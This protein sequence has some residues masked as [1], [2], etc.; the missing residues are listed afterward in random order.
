MPS[1]RELPLFPLSTVLFPGMVLPLHIF[2]ER[3]KTMMR[4][5]LGNH[6]P[7]GVVLI[8]EGLEVGSG[9]QVFN[10]GTAA[11]ITQVD[12]FEDGRMNIATLGLQRFRIHE[13]YEDRQPYLVGLV[14]DFPFDESNPAAIETAAE[15]LS[16][17]LVRYLQTLAKISDA[18]IDLEQVPKEATTL[19]FLG[20][21]VMQ[22]PMEEKQE[23]L[24]LESMVEFLQQEQRLLAREIQELSLLARSAPKWRSDPSPFSPN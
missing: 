4:H 7:F 11:H 8:R 15:N 14:E 12:Q 16:P 2:E 5:C 20:A 13:L 21:I 23:L 22:I 18:E 3:Y 1:T 24:S 6:E 17:V 19:A 10:I 9:A